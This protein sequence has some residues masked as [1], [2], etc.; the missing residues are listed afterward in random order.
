[1]AL[2]RT[3]SGSVPNND[4]TALSAA[5]H[6]GP[7]SL[8]TTL[9]SPPSLK[10]TF[11][12]SIHNGQADYL[13]EWTTFS[14]EAT[15]VKFVTEN[16]IWKKYEQQLKCHPTPPPPRVSMY[17][18]S[19]PTL[20][21]ICISQCTSCT[22]D[23]RSFRV[24]INRF[25][26]V[27]SHHLP[28]SVTTPNRFGQGHWVGALYCRL[29][30]TSMMGFSLLIIK[31]ISISSFIQCSAITR[32]NPIRPGIPFIIIPIIMWMS[33]L[34]QIIHGNCKPALSESRTDWIQNRF[35]NVIQSISR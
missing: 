2:T 5:A 13:L 35:S 31:I 23:C 33:Q 3:S 11:P 21:P 28:A 24:L 34:R 22:V 17:N 30:I 12:C 20:Q 16:G 14:S 25:P 29:F 1:M 6:V 10:Q 27:I 26:A 9:L 32:P 7:Q 4:N 19:S 18:R 8:N 15:Y